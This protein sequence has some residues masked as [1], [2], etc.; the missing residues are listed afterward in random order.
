MHAKHNIICEQ[1]VWDFLALWIG[2]P[3]DWGPSAHIMYIQQFEY[4]YLLGLSH[5]EEV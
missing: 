5:T 2:E 4:D 3:K 1:E